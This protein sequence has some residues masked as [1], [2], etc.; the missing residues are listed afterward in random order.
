MSKETVEFGQPVN[1][2]EKTMGDTI[3]DVLIECMPLIMKIIFTVLGV[4]VTKKIV[5]FLTEKTNKD[6][7]KTIQQELETVIEWAKIFVD[8]AQRLDM[9]GTLTDITNLNKKDYVMKKLMSK[10]SEL[11]Y[12]FTEEQL[13]EIR[14]SVVYALDQTEMLIEQTRDAV[15]EITNEEN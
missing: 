3:V 12:S 14:R 8:S 7:A 9:S 10:I 1:K 15:S 6:K 2:G 13:D 4:I 5:P 11:N